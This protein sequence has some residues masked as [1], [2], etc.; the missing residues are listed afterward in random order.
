MTHLRAIAP[1]VLVAALA[2][3]LSAQEAEEED[4]GPSLFERGA[5]LMLRGL[6]E[7]MEPA[8]EDFAALAEQMGPQ[9]QRLMFELGP[10]LRDL[11]EKVDDFTLYEMPEM[12]PNGDI[13]LRR[14][15]P[16]EAPEP[17][18]GEKPEPPADPIDI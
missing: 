12:L 8:M 11:A 15:P 17:D 6:V 1:L 10:A 4:M 16:L 7:E 14:K 2:A 5:E 9:L 3:P 18:G 13:I